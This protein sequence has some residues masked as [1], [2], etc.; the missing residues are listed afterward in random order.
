M[1]M[2]DE[3]LFIKEFREKKAE[4]EFQKARMALVEARKIEEAANGALTTFQV[5]AEQEE[6]SWY[7][8]LC[9]RVVKP[10]EIAYVQEDVAMLRATELMH[11]NALQKA[12]RQHALAHDT[13]VQTHLAMREA[14]KAREKFTELARM[15]HVLVNQEAERKEELELEEVAGNVR[16]KDDWGVDAD[17]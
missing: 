17:A 8:D 5:Q 11:A 13:H 16:K 14:S 3:L 7:R 9:S 1:A 12:E 15:H 2:I 10:R 6:Q 4:K